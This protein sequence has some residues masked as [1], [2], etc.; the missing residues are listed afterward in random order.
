MRRFAVMSILCILALSV[1]LQAKEK[2]SSSPMV[3][4]WKCIAHGGP[5]G[6]VQFTLYLQES[7]SGLTGSVSAPQGDAELT[8]VTFKDNHLKIE[9]NTD[10]NNYALTA[11]LAHGKLDG[12]WYLN[13]Q[14]QG[15]WNG[16][17]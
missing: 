13:G 2:G 14:K 4:T 7:T 6:D 17:K 8:S 9:I 12:T 3:G 1:T 10:E 11:I 16:T 15:T 5:N